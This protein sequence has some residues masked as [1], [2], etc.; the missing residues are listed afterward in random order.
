MVAVS[1]WI[2]LA[3]PSADEPM[4]CQPCWN[5]LAR[6]SGL[7]AI[8]PI[9]RDSRAR[10]GAGMDA[11]AAKAFQISSWKSRTPASARL[12][13]SG[14]S[15]L[16]P[17]EVTPIRRSLPARAWACASAGGSSAIC[18]WP[19]SIAVATCG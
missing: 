7:R 3:S 12:G 9:T 14:A 15:V 16:R 6:T 2:R 10:T 17:A 4:A 19:P 13:T 5:S 11:G 18:N 8:S 1:A